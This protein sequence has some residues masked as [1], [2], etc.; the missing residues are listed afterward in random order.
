MLWMHKFI[1]YNFKYFSLFLSIQPFSSQQNF[2]HFQ[3]D[4]Y[5][6]AFHGFQKLKLILRI[7]TVAKPNFINM[8][9]R[10]IDSIDFMVFMCI[11]N[12]Q[13]KP[14][15]LTL[16]ISLISIFFS[17]YFTRYSFL[18]LLIALKT[19]LKYQNMLDESDSFGL[20]VFKTTETERKWKMP[21]NWEKMLFLRAISYLKSNF[22]V[23]F[24]CKN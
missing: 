14:K 23:G 21:P 12:L 17:Y 13:S 5:A 16:H 3:I 10:E 15:N 24:K 19:A 1:N 8:L 2:D 6:Y 18:S 4:T 20:T 7:T 9:C 11:F 22:H